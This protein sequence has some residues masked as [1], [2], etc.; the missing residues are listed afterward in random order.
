MTVDRGITGS[1]HRAPLG[2]DYICN[3]LHPVHAEWLGSGGPGPAVAGEVPFL[4]KDVVLLAAAIYPRKQDVVRMSL[5]N[6]KTDTA[7]RNRLHASPTAKVTCRRVCVSVNFL[8]DLHHLEHDPE[9]WIP[10]FG[11]DHAP[12]KI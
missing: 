8:T 1:E 10:V 11:K 4:M 5:H 7:S 3:D 12:T 6:E 9:K 2:N